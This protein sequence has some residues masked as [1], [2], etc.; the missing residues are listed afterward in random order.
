V[1]VLAARARENHVTLNDVLL[2]TIAQ[3]VDHFGAN[4]S[5]PGHDEL[6]LGTV[7]DLRAMSGKKME[8]TFGLFL[9]FTTTMLRPAELK[10]FPRLLRSVSKQNAWHKQSKAP[11][12]SVLRMA[13][14][15][16]EAKLVSPRR[17][18]ELYRRRMP[19]AAGISNVNMNRNWAGPYHPTDI[20]DYYRVA[21]TGPMLPLLFTPT[22]LGNKLNFLITRQSSLID[23]ARN[24]QIARSISSRLAELAN[25]A[26]LWNNA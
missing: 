9:G 21:P 20:L 2:S 24:A 18:A 1:P 10:S 12:T 15:L 6:A 23:D 5:T 17:W 4:P 16:A 11:Q 25:D 8:D 7:V 19:I 3:A 13:V 22:T 14:G 26:R